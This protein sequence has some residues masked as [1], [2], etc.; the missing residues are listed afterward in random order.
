LLFSPIVWWIDKAHTEVF[1]FALLTITVAEIKDRPWSSMLAAAAS[2]Q[3]PPIAVLVPIVFVVSVL[4]HRFALTD[5]RLI[6]GAAA[7]V[8][9]AVLHPIYSYIHHGVWSLLLMQ[10]HSGAPTFQMLSAVVLD[11]SVGLIGNFPVFLIVVIAA[12]VTLLRH[13]RRHLLSDDVI[14]PTVT[15]SIFLFSFSRTTNVHHGGTPAVSRYALWLIPLALPLLAVLKQTD[16]AVWRRFLWS[17]AVMSALIS[18]FAFHP[19]VA[20]NSREPTWLAAF[21]WTRFPALNDP[22]PEVFVEHSCRSMT[23]GCRSPR[24]AAKRFLLRVGM[25]TAESGPRR[26]T[27]HGCPPIAR[28]PGRYVMQT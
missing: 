2:T 20:Q 28:R 24:A 19:S 16:G 22:L 1:T 17:A 8:A 4:R 15:A 9:L 26:V 13:S 3:N 23:C 10:T 6:I 5:R 12:L 18:V 14:I 27:Q 11:P 7:A 21:L 25:V